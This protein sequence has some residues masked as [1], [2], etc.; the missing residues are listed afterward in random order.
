MLTIMFMFFSIMYRW[1]FL[2]FYCLSFINLQLLIISLVSLN[3]YYIPNMIVNIKECL[4]FMYIDWTQ[5]NVIDATWRDN[6]RKPKS[7]GRGFCIVVLNL[8]YLL[9]FQKQKD[10]HHLAIQNILVYDIS[11]YHSSNLQNC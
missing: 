11:D 8:S 9:M 3:F 4:L 2:S 1:P 7:N 5:R 10:L 6:R